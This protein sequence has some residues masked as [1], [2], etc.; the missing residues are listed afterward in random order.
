MR[1]FVPPPLGVKAL[2][3]YRP[4]WE[5]A[6]KTPGDLFARVCPWVPSLAGKL[7]D[8]FNCQSLDRDACGGGRDSTR[9]ITGR[10]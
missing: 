3:H 10:R 7:I 9:I 2:E 4:V 1:A 8:C 6:E 5:V